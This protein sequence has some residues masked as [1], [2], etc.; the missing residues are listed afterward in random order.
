MSKSIGI[1]LIISSILALFVG[2]FIDINYGATAQ[3]T[4]RV[5]APENTGNFSYVEATLFSYSI[6]SLMMGIVFLFRV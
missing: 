6:I 1:L 5:V 4:G 3:I 2:A